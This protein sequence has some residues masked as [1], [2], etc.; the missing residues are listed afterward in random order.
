[1]LA[2]GGTILLGVIYAIITRVYPDESLLPFGMVGIFGF[3]GFF[4]FGMGLSL[5]AQT[6][7]N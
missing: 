3:L 1:L 5:I 2:I 6:K 4:L 7:K